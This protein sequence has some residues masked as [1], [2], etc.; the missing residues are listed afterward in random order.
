MHKMMFGQN[1]LL[2]E[3]PL[4]IL[5]F[6][7]RVLGKKNPVQRINFEFLK[8]FRFVVIKLKGLLE[9]DFHQCFPGV[10]GTVE[11]VYGAK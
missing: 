2:L 3:Q 5:L 9:N 7:S 10:A 6:V 8:T 11:Y 1:T 4:L